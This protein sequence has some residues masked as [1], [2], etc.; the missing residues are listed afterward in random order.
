M[1]QEGGAANVDERY[2]FIDNTNNTKTFIDPEKLYDTLSM[3]DAFTITSFVQNPDVSYSPATQEILR[4]IVY[5]KQ[6]GFSTVD[7]NTFQFGQL[8]PD[9]LT[10]GAG[11]RDV[12]GGVGQGLIGTAEG[13]LNFLQKY[14]RGIGEGGRQRLE[15]GFV[16]RDIL[17][18]GIGSER[19]PF[20]PETTTGTLSDTNLSEIYDRGGML[21]QGIPQER[22][23][24]AL[25]QAKVGDVITDFTPELEEITTPQIEDAEVTSTFDFR[26]EDLAARQPKYATPPDEFAAEQ[27]RKREEQERIQAEIDASPM[28]SDTLGTI[29]PVDSAARRAAFLESVE[30]LD[31]FGEPIPGFDKRTSMIE[32]GIAEALQE[33]TP[34]ENVVD[35]DRT[36][37]DSLMD[38]ENK[39]EGKFDKPKIDLT[40]VDTTITA[41]MEEAAKKRDARQPAEFTDKTKGEFREIFGSD[42]FLDFIRNVGGELVRTG[43]IGEGLASGAAKAA[44]ERATRD[45]LAEQEQK[46]FDRELLIAGVKAGTKDP[47]T[48]SELNTIATR[49]EELSENIRQF[50]KSETTLSNINYIINTLEAG[51][52]TGLRGFFGEATDIIQ[53]AIQSDTGERF[54]DLEPRTRANALLKVLRQAN[55]REILG[56]SG[57]TISNLDRKIV[58]DVFG[59]IK[60]GTPLS[61]SLK[62]LEDSRDNIIS[63]MELSRNKVIGAKSFFDKVNYQSNVYDANLPIIQIINNFDFENARNYAGSQQTTSSAGI[64]DINL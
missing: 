4:K 17:P 46:K 28:L 36:E 31:E 39:F 52:A 9:Y 48:V 57:R 2:F 6:S 27:Q 15:E 38:V 42:R 54:E 45:L 26:D 30:G 33:L 59:D 53:A 5:E 24:E 16:P 43:Q 41:E 37:A 60:L 29:D 25:S 20:S 19:M 50:Q 64:T 40:K 23:V 56:E 14:A 55:V 58:Q 49:E 21:R 32:D 1:F 22:L 44:E 18:G 13:A 63:G 3:S 10:T 61:V 8:L 62:K 7:P 12:A 35:I 34:I 11:V 51:G 47:L